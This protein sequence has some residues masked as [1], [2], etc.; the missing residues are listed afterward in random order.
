M[1]QSLNKVMLIGYLGREPEM[2]YTA[3][4]D[5]VTTFSVA[6]RR[7][8][9]GPGGEEHE[10]VDWFNV[11]AWRRLAEI[12]HERLHK[13]ARVY[14]EGRLQTRSFEDSD[15]R[16]HQAEIVLTEVVP[17]DSGPAASNQ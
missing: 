7:R 5:P 9:V 14:I 2:R 11:V 3:A 10:A 1:A 16:H 12:C 17:L 13:D 15:G 8:C 6:T 4:G